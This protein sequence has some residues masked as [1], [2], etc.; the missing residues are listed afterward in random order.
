MASQAE[1]P[2]IAENALKDLLFEKLQGGIIKLYRGEDAVRVESCL[3]AGIDAAEI[4]KRHPFIH[5]QN[6][7]MVNNIK[8]IRFMEGGGKFRKEA[9]G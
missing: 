1:I 7:R 2:V 5:L 4:K 3:K 9:I 6:I 8:A